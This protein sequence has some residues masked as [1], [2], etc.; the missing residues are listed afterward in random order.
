M[1]SIFETGGSLYFQDLMARFI[2]PKPRL[3]IARTLQII[4]DGATNATMI[5]DHTDSFYIY[6]GRISDNELPEHKIGDG[7]CINQTDDGITIFCVYDISRLKESSV[8]HHSSVNLSESV[9]S[10]G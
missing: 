2:T 6:G 4:P 5:A 8:S 7:M 3:Y 9:F 10:L 1:G